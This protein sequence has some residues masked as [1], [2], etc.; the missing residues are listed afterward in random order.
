MMI[1][2]T[3]NIVVQLFSF[4]TAM[5]F[6]VNF[7]GRIY[8]LVTRNLI[9]LGPCILSKIPWFEDIIFSLIIGI[10]VSIVVFIDKMVTKK[11]SQS[12]R[13][14]SL[15]VVKFND[16]VTAIMFF[17]MLFFC[18]IFVF[19]IREYYK[20]ELGITFIQFC[21]TQVPWL[22]IFATSLIFGIILAIGFSTTPSQ[23]KKQENEAKEE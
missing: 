12:K 1:N 4:V 19:V 13:I 16:F 5:V 8:G 11:Y 21:D 20:R 3:K 2:S 9:S 7:I 22:E 18:L 17:S 6:T 10:V 14:E 23:E 15:P